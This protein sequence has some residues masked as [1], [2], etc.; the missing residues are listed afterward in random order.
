MNES[1]TEVTVKGPESVKLPIYEATLDNELAKVIL[2]SGATTL[3]LSERMAEKIGVKVHKVKPRKVIVAD[4]ETTTVTGVVR[5][6]M[7]LGNLPKETITEFTFPLTKIDLVLGLPWLR[8]HNPRVDW[9]TLG[10]EFTENGRRYLLHPEKPPPNIRIAKVQE[11][12]EFVDDN[13]ALYL[14]TADMLRNGGKKSSRN[15]EEKEK[16]KK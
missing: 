7:K 16:K 4:K 8:K 1:G 3:Y 5:L 11:F 2:D 6:E 9:W 12:R 10:Y 14:I 15:R 13:T